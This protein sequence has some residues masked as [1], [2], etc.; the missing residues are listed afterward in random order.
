MGGFDAFGGGCEAFGGA[1]GGVVAAT[2]AGFGS[3]AATFVSCVSW[4]G[5]LEGCEASEGAL[6]GGLGSGLGGGLGGGLG[7]ALGGQPLTG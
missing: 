3:T 6:G 7:C 2:W 5:F 1:W 4:G